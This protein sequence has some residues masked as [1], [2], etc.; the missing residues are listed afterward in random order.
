[1]EKIKKISV[2]IERPNPD[3][4]DE[5][6]EA[7]VEAFMNESH[8]GQVELVFNADKGQ[9]VQPNKS[10]RRISQIALTNGRVNVRGDTG[11]GMITQ[12]SADHPEILRDKFD[13]DLTSEEQAFRSLVYRRRGGMN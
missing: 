5:D 7:N 10:I 13:K 6:L 2:I 9:S 12:S 1:M 4:F 8:T 11:A 3:I